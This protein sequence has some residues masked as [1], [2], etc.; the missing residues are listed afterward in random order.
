MSPPTQAALLEAGRLSQTCPKCGLTE[1]AGGYCTR[2]QTPT[3]G[4]D[5]HARGAGAPPEALPI[6]M[7]GSGRLYQRCLR[8][9]TDEAAGSY[10]T[11]CRTADYDLIEHAHP[12]A[13]GERGRGACPLG[14]YKNPSFAANRMPTKQR[15]LAE[16][17][18]AWDATHDPA[19][20]E[21]Y[22]VRRWHHAA[23]VR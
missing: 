6:S 5:Y 14:P 22:I 7:T 12:S 4:T 13:L 11:W 15:D 8:C 20:A 17:R 1:A 2:C 9:G 3:S 10:C 21:P 16:D 23:S 18:K 19:E